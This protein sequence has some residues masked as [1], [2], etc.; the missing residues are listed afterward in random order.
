MDL[1]K[2]GLPADIVKILFGTAITSFAFRFLTFPNHIVA[3]G[4]TG[5]SQIINLLTGFPI[6][7]ATILFNIPLFV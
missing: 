3:G 6:G 4:I 5:I 2:K 7:V 1:N